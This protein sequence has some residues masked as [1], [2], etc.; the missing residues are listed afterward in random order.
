MA[1]QS[2]ACLWDVA[3]RV[4]T[5]LMFALIVD[6]TTRCHS[7]IFRLWACI[8][9][10][11]FGSEDETQDLVHEYWLDKRFLTELHPQ[12]SEVFRFHLRT[13][14]CDSRHVAEQT[15]GWQ[16]SQATRLALRAVL[17]PTLPFC[18][19][20]QFPCLPVP[21]RGRLGLQDQV[22]VLIP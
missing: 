4:V 10:F 7:L 9:C 15:E 20:V 16:S 14:T 8:L 19:I 17:F 6:V 22:R 12:P 3:Y 1:W 21:E 11:V 13:C 18:N 2:E 5:D